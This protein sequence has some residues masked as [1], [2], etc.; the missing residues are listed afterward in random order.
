[1][2]SRSAVQS[3]AAL[4]QETR[5]AVYRLL[6]Q[7]G[8]S[9]MAAGEVAAQLDLAPATLSF[10][11]KELAHAGLVRARQAGRFIFYAADFDAMNA[12]LA[13]LTDN[14]CAADCGPSCAPAKACAP[15]SK[16][17]A[18]SGRSAPRTARTGGARTQG[19]KP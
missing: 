13:F 4:A 9:G 18:R 6:V 19:V 3:L 5:L 16:A 11:L 15:S 2:E 7:Q 8:P 1:M 14:C 12:L 10:H 17:G